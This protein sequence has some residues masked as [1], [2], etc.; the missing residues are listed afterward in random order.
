M[1]NK[2]IVEQG[3]MYSLFHQAYIHPINTSKLFAGILMILMNIG[4]KYI[5]MGLS[6]SQEQALRNGLGREIMIFCVVFLGTRDIVLSIIMTAAFVILSN[7]VFNENSR[8]CVIPNHLKKLNELIDVN[9]DKVISP[10]EE[11]QAMEILE[12]AKKI[13]KKKQ[14]GEFLS[15]M[16]NYSSQTFAD[17]TFSD[18]YYM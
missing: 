18:Q 4:S 9:D 16:D 2:L 5:E 3:G 13:R 15:Y 10:E 12:K 1:V 14:Q 11:K 17:Q 6:K 7:H 8:F